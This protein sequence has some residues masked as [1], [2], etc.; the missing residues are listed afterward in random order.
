M[1][2]HRSPSP[3][4][5]A[6]RR[7]G[8]L[9]LTFAV[10]KRCIPPR[11]ASPSVVAYEQV[12][13]AGLAGYSGRAC[14]GDFRPG[15]EGLSV[16]EFYAAERGIRVFSDVFC[17]GGLWYRKL[18]DPSLVPHVGRVL[19]GH[20]FRSEM[21]SFVTIISIPQSA[22]AYERCVFDSSADI[23]PGGLRRI[24]RRQDDALLPRLQ[25]LRLVS[26]LVA[27]KT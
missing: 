21:P 24:G 2:L 27:F 4:A 1:R 12:Y 14:G 13:S 9:Q 15:S 5:H 26:H 20:Q 23:L 8:E 19:F 7:S 11:A 18:D 16:V 3:V 22:Q 17:S 25:R 6:T 10:G